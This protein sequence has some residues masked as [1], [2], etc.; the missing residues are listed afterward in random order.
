[1]PL[2]PVAARPMFGGHGLYLDDVMF[3]FT[4]QSE[5]WLKTDAEAKAAFVDAG[6]RPFV[7]LRQGRE[8]EMSF[9]SVPGEIWANQAVLI[10]WAETALAV[11]RSARRRKRR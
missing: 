3:A 11:A 4:S 1:M 8:V 6:G 9:V 2:G 5:L 10:D 7:Y